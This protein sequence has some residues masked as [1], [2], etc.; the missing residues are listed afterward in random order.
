MVFLN[1]NIFTQSR[2]GIY[3]EHTS[4]RSELILQ[5]TWYLC[6]N[7]LETTVCV[8]CAHRVATI[9]TQSLLPRLL[10]FR[11]LIRFLETAVCALCAH[12]V[13]TVHT[14]SLLLRLLQFRMLVRVLSA[15]PSSLH[16]C[17]SLRQNLYFKLN[18]AL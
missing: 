12:R 14:Q 4:N 7:I 3:I 18:T 9:H 6:E 16:L 5:I 1:A 11:M 17:L 8:L 10:Q 15:F 2:T 13:V